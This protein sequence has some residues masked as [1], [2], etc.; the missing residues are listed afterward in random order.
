VPDRDPQRRAV[1][2]NGTLKRSPEPSNTE[3][4]AGYVGERLC[5]LGVR[6]EHVRLVYHH[7]EPGVSSTALSDRD[8]WPALHEKLLR[9]EIA[10]FATPT[11]MGQ[12]SS[13]IKGAL[14]RMD[15]MISE[16]RADG[17]PVA[18]GKVARFIVTGNEDR[19]HQSIGLMAAAANDIGYTIPGQAWTYW[20]K[21]PGPGEEEYATSKEQEWTHQ[22]GAT[23]AHVLFH[24]AR[25]LDGSSLPPTSDDG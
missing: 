11:W 20:N 10:I 5:E 25:A 23:M 24:A 1:F 8:G 22:T 21:G 9:A 12:P 19:A 13:V 2:L 16:T 4:L 3:A 14:E 7:V 18:W 6:V 17:A 15:A